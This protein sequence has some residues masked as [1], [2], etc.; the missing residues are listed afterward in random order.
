MKPLARIHQHT[1]AWLR[2]TLVVLQVVVVYAVTMAAA[3]W[4]F[5]E[6]IEVSVLNLTFA[7]GGAA[8]IGALT[9]GVLREFIF[10]AECLKIW[11][12]WPI[13]CLVGALAL[14]PARRG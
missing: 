8:T 10:R 9:F 1:P 5:G 12:A 13:S 2:P 14:E 11:G 6:R 7:G 4:M 3:D